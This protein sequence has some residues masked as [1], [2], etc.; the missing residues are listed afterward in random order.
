[1]DETLNKDDTEIER[2]LPNNIVANYSSEFE[3]IS[4]EEMSLAEDCL[5]ELNVTEKD[6]TGT[7]SNTHETP[8]EET[9]SCFGLVSV[10]DSTSLRKEDEKMLHEKADI[11][12][13]KDD[14]IT[15][16]NVTIPFEVPSDN[17]DG[18]LNV[19]WNLNCTCCGAKLTGS[20]TEDAKHY[21]DGEC[22][23]KSDWLKQGLP[24]LCAY[25]SQSGSHWVAACPLLASFCFTCW[26]WGHCLDT[27]KEQ[28]GEKYIGKLL[29]SY[30]R[31]RLNH[32][33]NSG[34]S[35]QY[36]VFPS[37]SR[38]EA[39]WRFAGSLEDVEIVSKKIPGHMG[40]P[41]GWLVKENWDSLRGLEIKK[42]LGFLKIVPLKLL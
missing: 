36:K 5:S 3:E 26:T 16:A 21:E 28:G 33:A 7:N 27:H 30:N 1:M 39:G 13:A 23:K 4:D 22:K 34:R 18:I 19:F 6:K 42:E 20:A 29:G 41:V 38:V 37:N 11:N 15:A 8:K 10:T 14:V 35:E 17:L 31:F 9:T 40:K 25:C 24:L 32:L 12:D 2:K